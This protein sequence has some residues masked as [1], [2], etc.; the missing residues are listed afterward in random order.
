MTLVVLNNIHVYKDVYID[1]GIH[2]QS[3]IHINNICNIR[4]ILKLSMR[5]WVKCVSV[6]QI[7]AN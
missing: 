4:Y 5:L 6:F 7:V 2:I 1:I 3:L